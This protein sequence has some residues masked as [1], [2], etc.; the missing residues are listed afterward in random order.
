[1]GI[2]NIINNFVNSFN[3]EKFWQMYLDCQNN[4]ATGI[5]RAFYIYRIKRMQVKHCCDFMVNFFGGDRNFGPEF[6]GKPYMPHGLKGIVISDKAKIGKNATI[7]QQVTVGVTEF[8]GNAP[9]IKDNVFIGAG[10]KVLGDIVIGNNV[11]IGANAVVL[12]DV[13][14][15]CT[16]V[17]IPA[18]IINK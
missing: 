5:K 4:K 13:P 8:G 9:T 3:E 11:K 14:D 1:M 17:G 18:K 6:A 2:S 12:H 10:A 16:V 15:N 7:F